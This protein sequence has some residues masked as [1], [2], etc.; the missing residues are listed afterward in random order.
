[1]QVKVA[2]ITAAFWGIKI[3]TTGA[4]EVLSDFLARS[5]DPAVAV[6]GAAAVLIGLLVAQITARRYRHWPYWTTVAGVAVVGTMAADAMHVVLGTDYA[7]ASV[8]FLCATAVVIGVWYLSE[9]TIAVHSITTRG[10]ETFYWAAVSATFAL[11]TAVGDLTAS[12]LGIGY[13]VSGLLFTALIAVPGLAH[14][15][16]VLAAVP[17]FWTAYV[18]TRPLGAS[19]ADWVA[20]PVGRGGLGLGT[21][22][23]GAVLLVVIAALVWRSRPRR[24]IAPPIPVDV[25]APSETR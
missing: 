2:E 1:M 5:I 9:S 14:H 21:G 13:L 16:R 18:L 24:S 19:F 8:V 11:G 12:S 6:L 4:G 10:R 3:L 23:V 22:T 25:D 17:A 20:V 15:R 7:T